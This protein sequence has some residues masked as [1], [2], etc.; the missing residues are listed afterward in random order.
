MK[1]TRKDKV[2]LFMT[3]VVICFV[4]LYLTAC[5]TTSITTS[6]GIVIKHTD[7]HPTGSAVGAEVDW[8][9]VGTL[10]FNRTSEGAEKVIE[11]ATPSLLGLT[12]SL[13]NTGVKAALR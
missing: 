13:L 8:D 12:S 5:T 11:A 1:L 7:F 6:D 2:D 3:V 4:T 9:G 10:K